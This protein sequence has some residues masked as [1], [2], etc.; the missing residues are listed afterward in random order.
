[1]S[2]KKNCGTIIYMGIEYGVLL[3]PDDGLVWVYKPND[4]K[5]GEANYG[6]RKA[7]DEKQARDEAIKMLEGHMGMRRK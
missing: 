3:N 7:N 4:P 2:T 5:F 6:D 1:M